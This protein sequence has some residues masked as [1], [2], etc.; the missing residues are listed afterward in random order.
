M[1]LA[2]EYEEKQSNY[3]K[4]IADYKASYANRIDESKLNEIEKILQEEREK[5]A[6]LYEK[7]LVLEAKNKE[8]L[9]LLALLEKPAEEPVAE[10]PVEE[11]VEE[12]KDEA[13]EKRRLVLEI[14]K[15]KARQLEGMY[16]EILQEEDKK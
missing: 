5:N 11:V 7:L 2:K 1:K 14:L 6:E 3:E 9:E 12:E 16:D 10:A 13:A 4:A 8:L 15:R